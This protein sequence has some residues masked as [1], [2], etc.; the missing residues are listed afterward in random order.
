MG[1]AVQFISTLVA[2]LSLSLPQ[3]TLVDQWRSI[4]P[5]AKGTVG[6]AALVIETGESAAMNDSGHFPTQSVYK[7][8][9]SMAI[10]RLV[11]QG[12]LS[13]DQS[14]D[15]RPEDYVPAEK[16][17]PLRDEY[18]KGTRQTIRELI[19]YTMIHSDG[20]A[21]DVLLKLAGGPVAVTRYVQSLGV[22]EFVIANSETDM[23]WETQYDDWCT[24]RAA[25]QLLAI[26]EK[27]NP[28]SEASRAL[29]LN[30]MRETQTGANRIRHLLPAGA[31]VAD[32]T[33][34][35]GTKNGRAVA[36]NDIALVTLPDGRHLAIAVF[37]MDSDAS[38]EAREGV[39]AKIARAAWDEWA[40]KK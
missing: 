11:D 25:V 35:S 20:T 26:L 38:T 14:V 32:K 33:G 19:R 1:T 10:L 2:I 21:S 22:S 3:Q 28:L 12:N 29:L 17:S 39:I 7:L 24:P 5:E 9:I 18:P 15:I 16:G 6:V 40:V 8:P 27:G 4:A 36:T 34:S 23:S 13:L 37:V 30:Y 31:T